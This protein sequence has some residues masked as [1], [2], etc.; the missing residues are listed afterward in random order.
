MGESVDIRLLGRFSVRRAGEEIPP[1]AFG[2]RLVRTLVRV[3][4]TRRGEFISHDVLAGALW[5]GRM[6]ANPAANLKVLVSRGRT[7]LGDA[8]LISTG[9]G[10]YSF[11]GGDACRVDAEDFLAAVAAGGRHLHDGEAAAALR[12]LRSALDSWGGEPLAEDAYE[13]WASDYRAA[14]GRAY[15][16]ALEEGAAAALAVRD[17]GQAVVLAEAAVA[18][19]PLREV[20]HLV[21][22][23]ALAVSGDQV[24]ALRVI[25]GLRLRLGEEVGLE[26]SSAIL[27]LERRIQRGES[28]GS[29]ARR[30]SGAP[31]GVA[32]EG[33][34]F[35]GRDEQL[36]AVL[37]ATQ[38]TPPGVVLVEG[39]A[40][41]GK[42]RLLAEVTDR[43]PL[44]VIAARA[45]L[46]EREEPWGLARSLLREALAL[47][48]EA[49]AT[50][51]ER[52]AVALAD[53]LPELEDLRALPSAAI[54]RESRRALA[55]EAAVGLIGAVATKGALVVVDD[56]QW[57]DP[58]SVHVLGLI[59][60]RIPSTALVLAYRPEELSS[61]E[62]VPS[63]L[64]ELVASRDP[65][66]H[67]PIGPLLLPTLSELVADPAVAEAI[68]R[69]TDGT[70]LAVA[71][72]VRR[73]A[74]DGVVEPDGQGRWRA[75][76][77]DAARLAGEI[78]RAG[79]RQG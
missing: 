70:P 76:T 52:A 6:P 46:P 49:A 7:A 34:R 30:P 54:D 35:V 16:R 9:P 55:L 47:D 14:L 31:A 42:S 17:P 2:G 66:I 12:V 8:A 62:A 64:Q 25:D 10:G 40:G 11:A 38:D 61:R 69:E 37:A 1:G 41:A 5:P 58:T 3:L 24:A 28:A 56:L 15:Q 51:P 68:A 71:E 79:Q 18:R 57:S 59:A 44:P 20:A 22:A 13:D 43:C 75:R 4:L 39:S 72:V 27:D 26:P 63:S 65:V 78:G 67:V 29:P 77:E 45:F 36:A 73:L 21:L 23:E 48:L 19:E 74:A 50:L 53:V 33:L 32:F 60:R